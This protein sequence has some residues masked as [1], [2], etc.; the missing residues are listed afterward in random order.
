MSSPVV[1]LDTQ[2]FS[3]FGDVLRGKADD[4]T[5][6][7]FL[8][9]EAQAASGD[10]I[11]AVSMPILAELLQ[12]DADFRQTTLCKAQAVAR[13]CGEW[14]LVYPSRLIASEIVG[15]AREAGAIPAGEPFSVLSSDR[16]WYPNISEAFRGLKE[17]IQ[18]GIAAEIDKHSAVNRKSRRGAKKIAGKLNPARAAA[19][20]APEMALTYG[21]PE[22]VFIR[23]IVALLRGAITPEEASRRLFGAIA[24]PVTFVETYFERVESERTLPEWIGGLGRNIEAH[25]HTFRD[26]LRPFLD[27]PEMR[28]RVAMLL[29]DWPAKL[30]EVVLRM[31]DGDDL[32]EFGLSTEIRDRLIEFPEFMARVPAASTVGRVIPEYVRQI[33]GLAG[34]EAKIERSFGGDLVHAFYLPHVDLWRG[35]RRFSKVVQDAVPALAHR[36]VPTLKALPAAIDDWNLGRSEARSR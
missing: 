6:T 24:E 36:I 22:D 21:L 34:N 19:E 29:A 13:L 32:A 9:L 18:S 33:I 17:Q 4:V 27:T 5:E 10:A 2:D 7:L 1:Y 35:D 3:R 8:A 20:A 12:Y 25:L 15:A 23:S 14:A 11:F 31:V 30:G 28:E 26:G 16:C